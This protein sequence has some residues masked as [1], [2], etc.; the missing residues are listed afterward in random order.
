MIEGAADEH[1]RGWHTAGWR[2]PLRRAEGHHRGRTRAGLSVPL[3]GMPA[4][5]RHCL[6]FRRHVATL[7]GA[8]RRPIQDLPA[9]RRQ[10]ITDPVLFL[11]ELRQQ[12]TLGKRAQPD[13]VRG[14]RRRAR[15][16]RSRAE[17]GNFRGVDASLARTAERDRT[18]LPGTVACYDL[19]TACALFCVGAFAEP[20]HARVGNYCFNRIG[21]IPVRPR[22]RGG[23]KLPTGGDGER[24]PKPASARRAIGGVSRF[25]AIPKPTVTVRMEENGKVWRTPGVS[26]FETR[27]P[28]L[29]FL[30][31]RNSHES[32]SEPSPG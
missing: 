23:V 3:Q 17:L 1:Q 22:S 8:A 19:S 14:G 15:Q 7:A 5:H 28:P 4:P 30:W 9:G 6:S 32:A 25:G 21:W 20:V 12:F 26:S 11:S 27:T 29:G 16:L 10:R 18:P 13:V 2:M 31:R 24:S